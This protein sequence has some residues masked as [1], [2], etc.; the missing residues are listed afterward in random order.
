M[1]DRLIKIL[2]ERARPVRPTEDFFLAGPSA[3]GRKEPNRV[4]HAALL[5][6]IRRQPRRV[7][8]PQAA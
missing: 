5:A 2:L 6:K 4:Q 8:D 7:D 3:T 1:R